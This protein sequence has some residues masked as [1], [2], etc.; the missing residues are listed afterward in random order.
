VR[1]I[2]DAPALRQHALLR[3]LPSLIPPDLSGAEAGTLL[4]GELL[5]AIER[6]RPNTPRPPPDTGRGGGAWLHYLVLHEAYVDGRGNDEITRRYNLAERT[7]YNARRRA[8]DAVAH[9]LA[10]RNATAHG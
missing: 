3:Y 5:Q 4:R 6:L 8:I 9:D 7:F 2:N 1:R 10:Q